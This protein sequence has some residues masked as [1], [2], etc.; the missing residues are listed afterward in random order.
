MHD[1]ALRSGKA[2]LG[3][4]TL[5]VAAI[6]PACLGFSVG[7]DWLS[8]RFQESLQVH[9]Q[10]TREAV[11]G[12]VVGVRAG[13][14]SF[15]GDAL[16]QIVRENVKTDDALSDDPRFHFDDELLRAGS[17]LLYMQRSAIVA[18]LLRNPAEG[19]SSRRLLGQALHAIQDFYSHSN[20][21]IEHPDPNSLASLWN[22]EPD[23]R[24]FAPNVIGTVCTPANTL[25]AGSATTSG[26]WFGGI[27]SAAGAASGIL[28]DGS[29]KCRHGL[30][31]PTLVPIGLNKDVPLRAFHTEA[32]ARAILASRDFVQGII[33]SVAHEPRAVCALLG[34]PKSDC[35]AI[36]PNEVELYRV[37]AVGIPPSPTGYFPM[38]SV[39]HVIQVDP[40]WGPLESTQTR[41]LSFLSEQLVGGFRISPP[42]T[43]CRVEGRW[44]PRTITLSPQSNSSTSCSSFTET[45]ATTYAIDA[46]GGQRWSLTSTS[47]QVASCSGI[48]NNFDNTLTIELNLDAEASSGSLVYESQTNSYSAYAAPGTVTTQQ[49]IHHSFE[50]SWSRFP[51]AGYPFGLTSAGVTRKNTDGSLPEICT[52]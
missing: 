5:A 3:L 4:V 14:R 35:V 21:V 1:L 16:E 8:E 17:R 50:Y 12:I 49:D 7:L 2:R 11:A 24:F 29:F 36:D 26:Y 46:S 13:P 25:L 41:Q 44:I 28:V 45:G 42:R 19:D 9:Q 37:S 31:T 20:W 15:N 40:I 52:N 18:R 43:V 33:A 27:D 22:A 48:T 34:Q 10:I 30:P 51:G 6:S 38:T 23:N 39:E 32:R 47:A